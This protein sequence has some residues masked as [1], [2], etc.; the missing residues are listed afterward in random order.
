[1]YVSTFYRHLQVLT[2]LVLD[3]PNNF[4]DSTDNYLC[5]IIVSWADS[6]NIPL[7]E[8]SPSRIALMK[9]LTANWV[10]PFRSLIQNIPDGLEARSIRIEDWLFNPGKTAHARVL[11]MGDSAHTMTM[12]KFLISCAR[13]WLLTPELV[14]VRG[15]GANNAIADVGDLVKRID[16][17]SSRYGDR[18]R[19]SKALV[20]S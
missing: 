7:P 13:T 17:T 2:R 3:T 16:F 10:E 11:M 18:F 12:C 14:E 6:K 1:M 15:E 9:Q 8:D 4:E 5:Q 20:G 19:C